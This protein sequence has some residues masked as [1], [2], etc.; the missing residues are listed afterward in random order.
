MKEYKR[1]VVTVNPAVISDWLNLVNTS[2]N[3]PGVFETLNTRMV[4]FQKVKSAS[5]RTYS[6]MTVLTDL[7]SADKT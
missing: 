2:G 6:H 4:A 5:V 3:K 7:V 1:R